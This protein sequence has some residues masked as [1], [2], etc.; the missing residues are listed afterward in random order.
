[1]AIAA[2]ARVPVTAIDALAPLIGLIR[3]GQY[4]VPKKHRVS[5]IRRVVIADILASAGRA[6]HYAEITEALLDS[7]FAV[8]LNVRDV[9]NAM[10]EDPTG[11]QPIRGALAAKTSAR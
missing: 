3:V 11:S 6:M 1:M 9:Q 4:L 7:G 10:A 8:W 2:E 5:D